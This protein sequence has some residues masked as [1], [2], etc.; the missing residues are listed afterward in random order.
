MS[1][2]LLQ[3]I[4]KK[5]LF[6]VVD[7]FDEDK[8]TSKALLEV[9]DRATLSDLTLERIIYYFFNHLIIDNNILLED[10]EIKLEGVRKKSMANDTKTMS[11]DIAKIRKELLKLHNYYENLVNI[12]HQ[13]LENENGIFKEERLRYLV[14]FTQRAERLSDNTNILRELVSQVR[15][16]Y[17]A[18]INL[19]LNNTMKLLTIIYIF[20]LPLTLIVGWYGMNFKHMPELDSPYGYIGVLILSI[21]VVII[22]I[23]WFKKKRFF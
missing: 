13:L 14:F 12:G 19:N 10:L 18:Q 8:S 1:H 11:E 5:N 21:S 23:L 22:S 6:V 7:I 9:L 17:L 3:S 15:D 2:L 4:I 16:A 20:F